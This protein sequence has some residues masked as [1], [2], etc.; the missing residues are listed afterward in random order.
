M[1]TETLMSDNTIIVP[2]IADAGI[3]IPFKTT[4]CFA[5]FV[6]FRVTVRIYNGGC[7][8]INS[9]FCFTFLC[10]ESIHQNCGVNEFTTDL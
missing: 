6:L 10:S 9:G 1:Y 3:V 4:S 8:D 5:N 2:F 7:N